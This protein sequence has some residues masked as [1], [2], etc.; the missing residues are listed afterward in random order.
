[1]LGKQNHFAGVCRRNKDGEKFL[2]TSD[3][4]INRIGMVEMDMLTTIQSQA[5]ST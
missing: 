2:Y 1:M 4:W 3:A 5:K